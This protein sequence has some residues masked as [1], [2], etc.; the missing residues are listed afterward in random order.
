MHKISVMENTILVPIDFS[1]QSLIGLEQTYNIA[2]LFEASITLIHVIRTHGPI[3]RFFSEKEKKDTVTKMEMHLR[4]L[5]DEAE[6][7]YGVTI[8]TIVEKGKIVET[9]MKV[10]KK[11]KPTLITIGTNSN[12][13]IG[14]RIIGSRALSWIKETSC[15]VMTIKGMHHREGCENIILPLDTK[16]ETKDKV[17]ITKKIAK[18]FNAK[19]FVVTIVTSKKQTSID[20]AETLLL[21]VK[22]DIIKDD[23]ECEIKILKSEKDT[24]IMAHK[25]LSY[26]HNIDADLISIMTQ[27]ENE[28][29]KFFI[30]SLAK[31]II[32]ASE[33]P[34][35]SVNPIKQ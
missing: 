22:K 35:I 8:N 18:F 29:K 2:K 23:V 24:D 1:E 9:V 14:N 10:A 11:I 21:Q 26:A 30:G 32:H 17:D 6:T 13:H 25:L 19:I 20:K 31:E 33:I 34:V 3:W 12:S 4:K 5:A 28:F 15:P 7:E 16:K 27:Q